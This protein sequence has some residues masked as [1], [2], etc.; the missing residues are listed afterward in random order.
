MLELIISFRSSSNIPSSIKVDQV[1][2]GQ[3]GREG[4]I[5]TQYAEETAR[6]IPVLER[7][8]AN[9]SIKAVDTEVFEGVG[10]DKLIEALAYYSSGKADKKIVVRVQDE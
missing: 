3:L 4:E 9:G 5:G 10:W 7:H 6:M 1:S 8:I 2:L